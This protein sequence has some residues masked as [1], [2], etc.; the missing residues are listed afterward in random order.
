MGGGAFKHIGVVISDAA[1][2]MISPLTAWENPD[3]P[4]CSPAA[5]E[6]GGTAAQISANKHRWE[7]A[8]ND[9]ETYNTVQSALKKQIITVVEPMYIDILNDDLVGF[10]NTTSQDMRDH[11]FLSYGSITAVDIEQN[12]E[13]M[14]KAW[15]P[16]QPVGTIFKKTQDC[17][18]FAE[19]GG[20]SIGA[21]QKLSSAYSK[22]SSQENST[23]P[24]TYGMKNLRPTRLGTT[25]RSILQLL[26]VS[27]DRFREKQWGPKS[28]PTK[29]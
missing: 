16:Q 23:V 7:E 20:V 10:A 22:K 9:F 4:G 21:A 17:V 19:A 29:R 24:A 2:E 8:I 5:I 3:F 12:F 13:N 25:S 11:L 18:D 27:T 1:Y 6:G 28:T 15:D 26:I 14:R